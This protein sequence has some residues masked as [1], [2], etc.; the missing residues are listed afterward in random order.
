MRRRT[1]TT[2]LIVAIMLALL[3]G[4]I[5]LHI[6]APP[7]A[8][9]L[10]PE[11]DGILYIDLKPLRT[12]THFDQH[13]VHHD[14]AYQHFIDSTGFVF[15]RDLNEAAFALHRMPNPL[16]PNGPV[17]FSEVFV[18]RF[19]R[20]RL[21]TYLGQASASREQYAGHTVFSLPSDGRTVRVT[22]LG[23][24][25]V[26]VSNAPTPEQIHAIRD[27]YRSAALPF[28]GSSVLTQYYRQVPA[29][30]L[31][32]GIGKI[33]LPLES[34]G[35][36][37]VFGMRIHLDL[38]TAFIASL[39]YLGSLRLRVEEIAANPSEAA[40]TATTLRALLGLLAASQD[41]LPAALANND[42]RELLNSARVE[43][44][45]DRA[46]LSAN[47]PV[48]LV[49]RVIAP[50]TG[51]GPAALSPGST[52]GTPPGRMSGAPTESHPHP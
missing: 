29:L 22:L 27:R 14:D 4:L 52:P 11:S 30:S 1:K 42:Y 28:S 20:K 8:A 36:P 46:I 48:S 37:R 12:A 33:T 18:G 35:G 6:Q 7:E 41:H 31:A 24:D 47:I 45:G 39:R 10:L 17:A 50:A 26:A 9:R 51:S 49:E 38:D 32:W 19:D 34:K 15:E 2:L 40:A 23:Y 25:M 3:G 43:Q 44:K 13:P 21:E 5:Y 16:G